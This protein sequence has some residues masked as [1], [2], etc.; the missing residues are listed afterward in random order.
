MF[1]NNLITIIV[2]LIFLT[3][4]KQHVCSGKVIIVN[5]NG[6]DSITCCMDGTCLCNSFYSALQSIENN[7]IVKITSKYVVL[8]DTANVGNE[9]LN[10]ITLIGNNVV[11]MCNNKGGMSWRSGDN[12]L[13]EGITWDQCGNPENPT[14]PAIKFESVYNI[15][16]SKC[17]FQHSKVCQTVRLVPGEEKEALVFVMNSVFTLNRVEN[18]NK[19][20]NTYGSI[21]IQDYGIA[22]SPNKLASIN[23]SGSLFHS[24]GNPGQHST[25]D[26]LSFAALY[27]FLQS[28]QRLNFVV[29][30]SFI[31]FNNITGI[32]LYNSATTSKIAFNNVT[33]FNNQGGIKMFKQGRKM[34]LDFV[35]CNFSQNNNGALVLDMNGKNNSV[36][37]NKVIFIKNKGAYASQG[38]ALH[39]KA[40]INTMIDLF[41]CNFENNTAVDGSSIVYIAGQGE[42][43]RSDVA[44]S[45]SSSRFVNN[46]G[47]SVL[48]IAQLR[49]TFHSFTL[50]QNNSAV[51]GTAIY[52]EQNG[53][54]T[55]TDDSSVQF[56]NNT[57]SLR[58]GAIFA[59]LANC[60]NN[61]ILFSNFSNFSS[62]TF[63]NNTARISSNSLYFNIPKSCNVQRDYT[64]N[65]S[66]AYIPFK[67]DYAPAPNTI[68]SPIGA[69]PYKIN[70]C[71]PHECTTGMAGKNCLITDKKML[72]ESVYF[73]ATVCNYFNDVAEPVQFRIKCVNCTKYRLLND[74]ILINSNSPDKVSILGINSYNDVVSDTNITLKVSS[75]LPDN[76]KEFSA[77]LSVTL[78]TCYNGFVFNTVTQKCECYSSGSDDIVQCQDDQAEIK[79]GYWYGIIFE[80]PMTSLCPINYCDFSH[81]TE[82]RNNYYALPRVVDG[83]CSLHRT[84]AVCSDCKL[85]YTLAFDSFDCVNVDQCSPGMTVLVIAL[86][87]LYWIIIVAIL[88]V[89]T[90]YFSTQVSSGYFNGVIYFYSIVD[91]LLVGNLYI[92]DGVFYVVAILSSF[93]KLTPQFLGRLCFIKRLNAIDQ[94]FIHYFH[95][96]CISL[97]LIGITIAAKYFKKVALYVNRCIS[98]VTYL[99]LLLSYTSIT[100]TSLQLLRGVQYDDSDGVFVYLSP[101][102]KYFTHRHGAYATVTLLCGLAVVIGLPLLLIA[103]PFLR[104]RANFKKIRP[105]INQFK[106][107]LNQ[108]QDSYEDKYQW[109]AA[110]YLLCRLTI[111]SIAYFGNRDH[112]D[113]VYYIQTA[114]V[115]IVMSLFCLRPYK[116]QLLNILDVAIL[117]IMLLVVNLNNYTFTKS[118]TAGLI[119]T[120]LL[121]PLLLLLGIGFKKLLVSL[122]M[123]FQKPNEIGIHH[124]GINE[125]YH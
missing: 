125:R 109:F 95:A 57:A 104:K 112:S 81:R 117:L 54:I 75:V 58:G 78:T 105:L 70:L 11:V 26:E 73:T 49:L 7:T 93:A 21:V 4:I 9:H 62:F 52:V 3:T 33:V 85:G 71:S 96:L 110:Y 42:S 22:Y 27:C 87:F 43:L 116:N 44:V 92:T 69:S 101:H 16:I 115:I 30:N 114:C 50:F 118:T 37:F 67:F 108:F 28:P 31:Y 59:D 47:G 91:V 18:A 23:I 13:I 20:G 111:M 8:E 17:T 83:Q 124:L 84:G 72:G 6:T 36:N 74:D 34:I 56:V 66:V 15:S 51:T 64:R 1:F 107:L 60:Y 55:V 88:F 48:R 41:H 63:I 19:C 14:N 35:L 10:N 82:T 39:I 25:H 5:N 45:T 90:Y 99:F 86:T 97:I 119:Y 121:I 123:K 102:I 38:A 32:Y 2:M 120:L 46:Q 100:S 94:Q 61:G 68:G 79:L 29:E 77:N 98:R 76:H 122:R 40:N 80:N 24:N 103:E 113:M 89:L 12:I 53:F 65:D 106:P